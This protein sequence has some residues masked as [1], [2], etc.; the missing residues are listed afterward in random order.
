MGWKMAAMRQIHNLG[1]AAEVNFCYPLLGDR[2]KT[3]KTFP[4]C[5][6]WSF[7]CD[8][9]IHLF[10]K[11][12]FLS[13]CS[14]G[15]TKACQM[16]YG[17]LLVVFFLNLILFHH[18]SPQ[19]YWLNAASFFC[20]PFS[21]SC[22]ALFQWAMLQVPT[23]NIRFVSLLPPLLAACRNS[24]ASPSLLSSPSM[25]GR[26]LMVFC[27]ASLGRRQ[28]FSKIARDKHQLRHKL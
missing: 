22:R 13:T 7:L 2:H 8:I 10:L 20:L 25:P 23:P 27:T 6:K 17:C 21:F 4:V 1:I 5:F 24:S 26:E 15:E 28:A 3:P 14:R 16:F 11:A 9:T 19:S 12:S 18:P